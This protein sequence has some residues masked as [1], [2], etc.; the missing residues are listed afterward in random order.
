MGW[1][2]NF[3]LISRSTCDQANRPP[4]VANRWKPG[5]GPRADWFAFRVPRLLT[6]A[7]SFWGGALVQPLG[8]HRVDLRER[9]PESLRNSHDHPLGGDGAREGLRQGGEHG[10]SPESSGT[11]LPQLKLACASGPDRSASVLWRLFSRPG[12]VGMVIRAIWGRI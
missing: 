7:L 9:L 1:G 2:M 11:V 6:A 4:R 3:R 8:F 5:I 10:A 12:A